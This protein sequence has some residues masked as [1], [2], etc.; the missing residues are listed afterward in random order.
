VCYGTKRMGV[1]I[2]AAAI[3]LAALVGVSC[4]P[5]NFPPPTAKASFAKDFP[6]DIG[7]Y[8]VYVEGGR[9]DVVVGHDAL[10]TPPVVAWQTGT[11]TNAE[12]TKVTSTSI[13]GLWVAQLTE[14]PL[15]VPLTYTVESELGTVG[16]L[17]FRGGRSPGRRFR[18]A[19]FG[20]TRTGHKVHRALIENMAKE[21]VDLVVH[22]GD[23]VESGGVLDQWVE[24]FSIEAPVIASAPLIAALGNHDLSQRNHYKRFILAKRYADDQRYF[25]RDWGDVR[26]IIMDS[27]E[28]SRAGSAQYEFLES[29]MRDGAEKD[30]FMIVALHRPPYSAGAHGSDLEMREILGELCPRFG[31]EVVLAGHDHNYERTKRID[32]VTYFV[33]A[34]GGAP[35]RR[36]NPSWFSEVVRTEPHYVIFDLERRSLVGRAINLD[37]DTFDTFV[38]PPLDPQ[39][40]KKP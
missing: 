10:K 21:N 25:Y 26:V 35:I 33:A 7:P 32:G 11:S 14:L 24:F 15:D 37:G 38:I 34:S 27:E 17:P 23:L 30:M 13:D 31:V 39:P 16:P 1:R 18:F 5:K 28:E 29:A 3:G 36:M 20:D 40:P 6:F 4:Y 8:L 19:A 2:G 22:S 9:L 12:S